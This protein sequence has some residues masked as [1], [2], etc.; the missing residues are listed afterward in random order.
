MTLR[1]LVVVDGGHRVGKREV[2]LRGVVVPRDAFFNQAVLVV[3][4]LVDARLADV[5][6]FGFLAVNGVAEVL[7]V[8]RNG[9]GD[10]AGSTTCAKKV[11]DDL[12][13]GTDLSERAVKVLV[14]VDAKG[15]L[16]GRK[17]D[18]FQVHNEIGK[19]CIKGK[20]TFVP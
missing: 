13:T 6:A 4:H 3:E 20:D 11:S 18:A 17:D 7:V 12:L 9:L 10:G 1:G 19:V 5:S 15:L 14:E 8:G 16:L 2:L